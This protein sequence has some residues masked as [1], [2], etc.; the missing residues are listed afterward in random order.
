MAI[1]H[2]DCMVYM[3]T[4]PANAFDLA[5][6]DPPYG[7]GEHGGIKR[8]S[9]AKQK[10]GKM[11]FVRDGNYD[12]KTWD[13]KPPTDEYFDELE[14]VSVNQ[15]IFGVNY[16]DRAF[17]GGRIVW[18][19]V[20]DGANQ[21]G[22]EIAYN[23]LNQRVDILRYMW[24]GML[25]GDEV[26]SMRAQGNKRK[27][28]A[29]IHPTQKP[30][31]LY[32]WILSRYAEPGQWIFDTHLGSGSSAIAAHRHNFPFVGCEIDP[33]YHQAAMERFESETSQLSIL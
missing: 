19:K 15:I 17:K 3:R 23:S 5:I 7:R 11:T 6:V 29:R 12:K 27:Q 4:L 25:Q 14:R 20:N 16:F 26:G 32:E 18:D 8:S 28:E 9:L 2:I 33:G 1:L 30:I 21:S 31:K 24:R 10:N 13:E 22:A